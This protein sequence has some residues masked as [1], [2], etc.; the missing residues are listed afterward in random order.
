MTFFA[1]ESGAES[2][3]PREGIEITMLNNVYRLATGTRPIVLDGDTYDVHPASRGELETSI[4]GV[5]GN[6][7]QLMINL[8]MAHAVPQRWMAGG[9]PPSNIRVRVLRKQVTSGEVEHVWFGSATAM[10][11]SGQMAQL[12]VPSDLARAM[13][14]RLPTI[15]VGRNCPHM[16][17]D[18]STCKADRSTKLVNAVVSTLSGRVI[19][20][21]SVGGHVDQW[22]RGGEFVHVASGERMTILDQTGLTLTLQLPIYELRVGATLQLYAGCTHAIS[23]CGAVFANVANFGGMPLLPRNNPMLPTKLG[24]VS[25]E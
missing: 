20:V 19:K 4:A 7:G 15:T 18:A 14:R 9:V 6:G 5:F 8:P 11:I 2:S 12:A 3:I 23:Y 1:D 17:Y 16:L 13:A 24:T 25:Q 22:M 21:S 10:T